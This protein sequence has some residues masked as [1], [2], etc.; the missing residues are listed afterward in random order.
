METVNDNSSYMEYATDETLN[1]DLLNFR[2]ALD[3]VLNS[4]MSK[5]DEIQMK[6]VINEIKNLYCK[7]VLLIKD[8]TPLYNPALINKT[9]IW[10]TKY[11]RPERSCILLI[12]LESGKLILATYYSPID[13]ISPMNGV[14]DWHY[15]INIDIKRY[16]ILDSLIEQ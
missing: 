4:D 9:D 16:W 11:K 3:V 10:H 2:K 15:W 14:D 5:L 13:A 6:A 12:Q 7:L 8:K 1:E